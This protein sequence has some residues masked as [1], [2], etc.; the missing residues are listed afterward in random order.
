[1]GFFCHWSASAFYKAIRSLFVT[2]GW[3]EGIKKVR[4]HVTYM[5]NEYDS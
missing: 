3:I 2:K 1:V 5:C 4:L